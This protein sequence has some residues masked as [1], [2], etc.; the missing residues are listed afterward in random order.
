MTIICFTLVSFLIVREYTEYSKDNTLAIELW[1]KLTF[2]SQQFT[3]FV[4]EKGLLASF[5]RDKNIRNFYEWTWYVEFV[6][7]CC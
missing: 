6:G 3:S 7:A 2:I 1:D 4:D 5:A